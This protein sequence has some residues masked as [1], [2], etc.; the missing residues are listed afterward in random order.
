MKVETYLKRHPE[1]AEFY[2]QAKDRLGG[3]DSF[4]RCRSDNFDDMNHFGHFNIKRVEE[5]PE[6]GELVTLHI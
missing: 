5:A 3:P 4:C 6:P 2:L 1:I